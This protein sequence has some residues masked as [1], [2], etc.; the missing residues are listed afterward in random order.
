MSLTSSC[1]GTLA[2]VLNSG[3]LGVEVSPG[4]VNDGELVGVLGGGLVLM[5]PSLVSVTMS[6]ATCS[7]EAF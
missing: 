5:L 4:E 7:M 3:G 2:L 1:S 6:L